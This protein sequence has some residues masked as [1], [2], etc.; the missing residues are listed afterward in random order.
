VLW[1]SRILK[2]DSNNNTRA[3]AFI[4]LHLGKYCR[5]CCNFYLLEDPIIYHFLPNIS[6]KA[7]KT[8][9]LLMALL[10]GLVI[11]R[12]VPDRRSQ[13]AHVGKYLKAHNLLR[14]SSTRAPI[15]R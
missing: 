11:A 4:S 14:R 7:R 9:S 6:R 13:K 12:N 1:L 2:G 3:S 8:Y 10:D 15:L 5:K